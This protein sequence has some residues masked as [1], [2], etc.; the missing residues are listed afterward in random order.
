[1]D[2]FIIIVCVD[3]TAQILIQVSRDPL[4][5]RVVPRDRLAD[6]MQQQC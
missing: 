1:M 4:V 5:S 3:L 6:Y 2:P